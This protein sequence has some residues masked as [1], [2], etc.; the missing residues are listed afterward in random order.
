MDRQHH[1][2]GKSWNALIVVFLDL[3]ALAIHWQ[4]ISVK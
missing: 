4:L 2:Y 1:Y 3:M